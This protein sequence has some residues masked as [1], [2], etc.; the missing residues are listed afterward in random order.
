MRGHIAYYLLRQYLVY[1]YTSTNRVL[2]APLSTQCS[3]VSITFQTSSTW[4]FIQLVA[5]EQYTCHCI[6]TE[7]SDVRVRC[8]LCVF[9]YIFA[10][11]AV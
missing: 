6:S 4:P 1:I 3:Q 9:S 11:F 7:A 2:G 8:G 5:A 10:V